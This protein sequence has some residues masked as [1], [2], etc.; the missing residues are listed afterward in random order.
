[1]VEKARR[2]AI[3]ASDRTRASMSA[4]APLKSALAR[5]EDGLE[6]QKWAAANH[7]VAPD[8]TPTP[9]SQESHLVASNSA[10]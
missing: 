3:R 8:W 6:I 1:M 9:S 4:L 5:V 7:F 2:E 10:R